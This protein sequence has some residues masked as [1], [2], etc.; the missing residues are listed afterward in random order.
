[1]VRADSYACM[2]LTLISCLLLVLLGLGGITKEVSAACPPPT[3]DAPSFGDTAPPWHPLSLAFSP[4]G[5]WVSVFFADGTVLL[6]DAEKNERSELIPCYRL[7]LDSMIFSPDSSLLALGD[8]DGQVRILEVPGGRVRQKLDQGMAWIERM[9]FSANGKLLVVAHHQGIVVWELETRE[10]IL[11]IPQSAENGALAISSDGQTLAFG[12]AAGTVR[13]WSVPLQRE[14]AVIHLAEGD[15]ANDLLFA[16][17]DQWLVSA[18]GSGTISLWPSSGGS[19]L[20]T[21]QGHSDQVV[22]LH[23]LPSGRTLFSIDDD[24]L[25]CSWSLDSGELLAKWQIA[26]GGLS[27]SAELL[28]TY[29]EEA[30]E[31]QIWRVATKKKI[32]FLR[33]VSP[34]ETPREPQQ[35]P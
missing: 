13:I 19:R 30:R 5:K 23:V 11:A 2:K 27:D 7:S 31:V 18:Q 10:K 33:Y 9:L 3:R 15:W 8:A 4:S 22:L 25:L 12:G 1:M 28:A 35:E 34:H 17:S 6:W 29:D 16:D 26:P 14:I 21:F 32:S 20:R 24:G